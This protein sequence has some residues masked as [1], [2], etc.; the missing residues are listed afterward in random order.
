MQKSDKA[1][2]VIILIALALLLVWVIK[3]KRAMG[4]TNESSPT[5]YNLPPTT[6][7]FFAGD[8]MLSR[9]V[10]DKITQAN[11]YNL[12]F[13]KVAN[14][15]KNVDIAFANLESPFNNTGKHFI[16]NS[17][18]FNADP[19]SADGLEFAGFDV[20]STANNHSLDQGQKGL[21]YTIDVLTAHNT[22][23]TGTKHSKTTF[24]EPVIQRNNILF[25]FL[26]YSYTALNDG[27]KSTSPY[28]NDFNDLTKLKQDILD[29]KGHTADVVIVSM[30]AGTEYKRDPN[31][32][33]VAFAHAAIDAGS[34]LVIGHHPHWIQ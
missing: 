30:H 17:L 16:A 2:R 1:A 9:N 11:D 33:Q 28:I 5:T 24:R 21:D 25:G 27:G 13:Q 19:K 29:M 4:P 20:M 23:P 3:P 34:D 7:L 18:V 8:I 22:L 31:D 26:A 10:H 6:S 12:P 32:S 15:I 14:L